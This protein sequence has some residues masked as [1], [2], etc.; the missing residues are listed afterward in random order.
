MAERAV[1]HDSRGV[2]THWRFK[3]SPGHL[4]ATT[5][6]SIHRVLEKGNY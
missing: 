1:G 5:Y 3:S 4:C 2:R 6:K